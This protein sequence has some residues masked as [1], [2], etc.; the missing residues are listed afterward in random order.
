MV[1]VVV[2]VVVAVIIVIAAA[3][4]A[5]VAVVAQLPLNGPTGDP[6]YAPTRENNKQL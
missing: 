2:V 1:F 6:V 3:A 5:V 4:A